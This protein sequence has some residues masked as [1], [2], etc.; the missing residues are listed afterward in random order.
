VSVCRWVFVLC[1]GIGLVVGME[2]CVGVVV[3]CGVGFD[4]GYGGGC[5]S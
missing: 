1:V 5:G 4:E 2:C 3:G